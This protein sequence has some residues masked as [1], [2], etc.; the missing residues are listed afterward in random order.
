[1]TWQEQCIRALSDQDLFE[2]SWHKT[3]FKELLDCYI[4]YPFFT[5]GLCK[6]MY[7]SVSLGRRTFLYHVRKSG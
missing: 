2:D 4:S 5:K 7:V 6:C 3:R 1:M